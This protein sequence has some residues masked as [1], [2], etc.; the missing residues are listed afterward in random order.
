[1]AEL[2]AR[3]APLRPLT[4]TTATDGNHG[5]AVARVA[6]LLGLQARIFVPAGTAAARI[7][8]IASEGAEV[9]EVG[10]TYDDAVARAAATAG[11][12]CLV[13]SDTSWPGYEE[14][15]RWVAEGYSTIGWE[16][17]D[18]LAARGEPGPDV[19]LVQIGVGALAAAVVRHFRRA[20]A[21]APR[22]RVVGVEPLEADCAL[23]SMVAG[24][25]VTLPG[26]QHSIMAGLNCGTPSPMAWPLVSGGIA[27]FLAIEDELARQAMRDLARAGV[28]AG[29]TGGA[30]LGG[31]IALCTDPAAAS[32]RAS[33]AIGPETRALVICTEGATDPEAYQRIV[34]APPERATLHEPDA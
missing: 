21:P 29:E 24:R 1:V 31:L 2:A 25:I 22:A 5:R 19:V 32:A 17:A 26:E 3:L 14:I 16:I 18:A 20:D 15:P 30:G 13:I 6:A 8:G 7:A 10:G 28:V 27:L 34:G 23:A 33:L 9:V 4:L 12:R 11:D